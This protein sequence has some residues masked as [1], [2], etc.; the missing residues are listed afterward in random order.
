MIGIQNFR[1]FGGLPALFLVHS[2]MYIICILCVGVCLLHV[3]GKE[4]TFL[5]AY[6]ASSLLFQLIFVFSFH[7]LPYTKTKEKEKVSNENLTAAIFRA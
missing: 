4:D 7:A 3:I 1:A 5:Q 6:V 2:M